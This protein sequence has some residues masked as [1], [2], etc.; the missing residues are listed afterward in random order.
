MKRLGL[1]GLLVVGAGL[2]ACEAVRTG[3]NPELPSWAHRPSWAIDVEYRRNL[4]AESRKVGEAYE[5]GQPEIDVAGRRVF[6]GSSDHGLYALN[7]VNGDTLWRFETLGPVQCEPLY[8]PQE[9]VVYF[10]SNDGALY[11]VRARDGKLLWRFMSNAEINKRPVLSGGLL[12]VVNANDTLLAIEPTSG[13][14][15]WGQHRAPAL[16]M[17]VAGHSGVLVWQGLAYLAY[18]DGNVIAYDAKTGEE[19][20]QPVDLS[21]EA[22]QLLG[23]VPQYLDVDTTPEPLVLPDG[24]AI[25]V[26]S[27]E[28]GV[29]ALDAET[30]NQLW[31]NPAI[32]GVTDLMHWHEPGHPDPDGGPAIPARDLLIAST[33]TSGLW[34]LEPASGETVWHRDLPNGGVSRPVP[35][36]GAL[37]FSTSQRGIYLVSPL[38]GGVIDGIHTGMGLSMAPAAH[39]NRAFVLTN[40]GQFLALHVSPPGR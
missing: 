29:Y 10:G 16:G 26:G 40:E 12:Y 11:R 31:S 18:S 28:G 21:A 32:A 15:R 20:W 37:L 9:D 3:A 5:R 13:K 1:V 34:A 19:R 7:A 17:E 39:G 22:E 14:V 36:A 23:D 38:D 30:G 24:P 25:G 35:I 6:V 8:D 2:P 4:L 33:G 27:Y